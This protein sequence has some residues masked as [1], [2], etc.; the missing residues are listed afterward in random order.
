MSALSETSFRL[1]TWQLSDADRVVRSLSTV[2]SCS[3]TSRSNAGKAAKL[4]KMPTTRVRRRISR[5]S[6]S[7]GLVEL[8]RTA[9][10]LRIETADFVVDIRQKLG[11]LVHFPGIRQACLQVSKRQNRGAQFSRG[12]PELT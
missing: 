10:R 1:R 7:S 8:T 5:S 6:R 9:V 4:G 2:G 12:S 3:A 11:F